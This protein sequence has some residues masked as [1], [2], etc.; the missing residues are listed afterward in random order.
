MMIYYFVINLILFGIFLAI[1]NSLHLD[2]EAMISDLIAKKIE[3][4]PHKGD[5][6]LK[7]HTLNN[8]KNPFW[9]HCSQVFLYGLLLCL[10]YRTPPII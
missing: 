3:T 2:G 8:L 4:L 10:F 7:L 1:S 5:K 9:G 6:P